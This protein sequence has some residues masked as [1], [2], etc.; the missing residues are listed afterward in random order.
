MKKTLFS[1]YFK[2]FAVSLDFY[3]GISLGVIYDKGYNGD[4]TIYITLPFFIIE[5]FTYGNK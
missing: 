4:H 2:K 3:T 5:T 1:K